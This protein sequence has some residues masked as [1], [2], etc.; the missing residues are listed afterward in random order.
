MMR[1]SLSILPL[2]QIAAALFL[3]ILATERLVPRNAGIQEYRNSVILQACCV[4]EAGP[5]LRVKVPS[6]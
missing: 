2:W 1:D 3:R 6:G 5:G 4:L